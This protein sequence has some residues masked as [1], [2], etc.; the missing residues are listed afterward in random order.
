MKLFLVVLIL[1]AAVVIVGLQSV[2]IVDQTQYAVVIRFGE[3]QRAVSQPGLQ[4][5]EPF[6]EEVTH[7]D[8]RLLRIDMSSE[9]MQDKEKQ[10][11]DIDAYVRYRITDPGKF[12]VRLRDENTAESRL[13]N[14]V[15]SELRRVV[16][17]SD[18][19]DIIGGVTT[20]LPDGTIRVD[21]KRTAEGLDTRESI[22]HQVIAGVNEAVQSP[23]NDYG[24]VITDVRIKAAD[25]PASVEQSVFNRMRTEREVQA[26]RL[27]AE[28]EQQNLTITADVDRQVT[29]IRSE[30]EKTA[31]QLRGQGEGQAIDIYA[32]ALQQD[33]EFYAFQR[34]LEAYKKTLAQSTTLVLSSKDQFFKYLDSPIA[35]KP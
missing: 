17:D 28:G 1:V 16:A 9:P 13:S 10:I 5:K 12:L 3:I 7:F 19:T 29:I 14:I 30:A 8:N 18:R 15:T 27:R 6:V 24:V 22:T 35:P 25:F 26:K 32:S 23:E 34:T 33:P 20:T 2:F 21:P 4:F 31:N 11:L